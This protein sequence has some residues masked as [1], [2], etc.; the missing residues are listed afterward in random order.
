MTAYENTDPTSGTDP[1][2]GPFGDS[3]MYFNN[4]ETVL[5]M[6]KVSEEAAIGDTIE[7]AHLLNFMSA[8]NYDGTENHSFV[9]ATGGATLTNTN[10]HYA[11]GGDGEVSFEKLGNLIIAEIDGGWETQ[12]MNCVTYYVSLSPLFMTGVINRC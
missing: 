4:I 12:V 9:I 11:G 5:G 6:L 10:T 7:S 1:V 2:F 3:H 8:I